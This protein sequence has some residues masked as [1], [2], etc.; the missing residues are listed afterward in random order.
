MP[1]SLLEIHS[2]GHC[3]AEACL[4]IGQIGLAKVNCE[5]MDLEKKERWERQLTLGWGRSGK[6][7]ENEVG[8]K[9]AFLMI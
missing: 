3:R 7:K 4:E 6:P 9:R 8:L 5:E 1:R 2:I